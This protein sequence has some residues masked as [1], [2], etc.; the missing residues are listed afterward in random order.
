[1]PPQITYAPG[2][3]AKL[4]NC[5]FHSNAV[6]HCHNSTSCCLISSMFLTHDTLTLL[7]DFLNLV[8]HV[9]SLEL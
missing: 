8:I 4:K 9:L 6:V 1:M 5:I 7:Y 2:Q 3:M